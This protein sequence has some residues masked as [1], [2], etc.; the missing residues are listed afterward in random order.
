MYFFYF[1]SILRIYGFEPKDYFNKRRIYLQ[2]C[3]LS[4]VYYE[5]T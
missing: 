3:F 2:G 4:N 5:W 1:I